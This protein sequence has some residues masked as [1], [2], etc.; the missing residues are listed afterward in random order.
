[1]RRRARKGRVRLMKQRI[2]GLGFVAVLVA[3][4]G[5]PACLAESPSSAAVA[6]YNRYVSGVE[7]R[8]AEGHRHSAT[9]LEG[10]GHGGPE[11]DRVLVE[12][13]TPADGLALPGA[14][15]HDWRGA[16]FISGATVREFAAMLQDYEAYPQEFAPQVLE[17]HAA[18][19]PGGH[20]SV[21]MQVLQ[22]HV[23]SVML[24]SRYDVRFGQLD[25][26]HGWSTSRSTAI[27]EMDGAG[28]PLNAT[29]QHGF[30]WRLDTWWSY[31]QCGSGLCVEI[32][33]VSLTRSVPTGMGWMIGP[34][35]ES[36]P[37]ESLEFTLR[38]A[39]AAVR[40]R[41]ENEASRERGQ[42]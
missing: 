14:L 21:E 4:V 18:A 6:G 23:I 26:A 37:R 7:A 38:H 22:R 19:E 1:M 35:V 33:T 27:Q 30:L 2:I 16:A 34:F 8:I 36:I 5:A 29:D 12:P 20:F 17:A 41:A 13:V 39:C 28:R 40:E 32:E 25:A 31:E 42:R 9:F 24:D 15:L 10:I 11:R 3:G